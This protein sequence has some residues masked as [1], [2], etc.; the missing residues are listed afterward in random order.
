MYAFICA[1]NIYQMQ[2]KLSFL[3]NSTS[4]KSCAPIEHSN[5]I[6]DKSRVIHS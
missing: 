2:L 3:C 1:S 5:P 6:S 4:T